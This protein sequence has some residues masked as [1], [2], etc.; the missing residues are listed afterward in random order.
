MDF[1]DYY[2]V[3][4]LEPSVTQEEI[5]RTYKKLA[6]K[7]HP[8]VS[9]EE[10]AQAKFQ[11]VSEAYEVLKNAD[12]RAEYDALRDQVMNPGKYASQHNTQFDSRF[13]QTQF[14]DLLRSI[15]GDTGQPDFGRG[16]RGFSAQTR[17]RDIYHRLPISLEAAYSGT[18]MALRLDTPQGQRSINVKIPKGI[19]AGKELRLKGL[20]DPGFGD[21]QAGDLF[22]EIEIEKHQSFDVAGDDITLVLPVTPWEA[23][24]GAS[25][26]VPTLG[27]SVSLK[28]PENSQ[29]GAKLRLK[30]RGLGNGDQFVILKIVN[31]VITTDAQRAAFGEVQKA[32]TFN[33]RSG[34]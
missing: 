8:D 5:K 7:Y 34:L 29:N 6:R 21:G 27:G 9:D 12:K 19:T 26:A 17:G 24:L 16:T 28:I 23:A 11:E 2:K 22:L 33:P 10:D 32:F 25:V 4:A 30:G 1:K 15:F 3:L 18:S 13:N 20:G 14:D 31:P